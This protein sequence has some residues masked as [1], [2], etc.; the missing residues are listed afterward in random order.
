MQDRILG[1]QYTT[2]D[3]SLDAFTQHLNEIY[4]AIAGD[5][6]P[7]EQAC[8]QFE[9]YDRL[10]PDI[11]TKTIEDIKVFRAS[12]AEC[13]NCFDKNDTPLP[14][15][16]IVMRLSFLHHLHYANSC[17]DDA[18]LHLTA[19]R[20]ASMSTKV[21]DLQARRYTSQHLAKLLKAA[22]EMLAEK[23]ADFDKVRFEHRKLVHCDH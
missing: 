20:P 15:V 9:G 19:Y 8:E 23:D 2:S 10:A 22:Q 3:E 18:M 4:A 14:M 6:E 17:A 7:I 12:I 5:L 16:M 1:Y 21:A 11:C 13:I